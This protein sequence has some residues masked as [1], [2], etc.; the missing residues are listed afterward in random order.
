MV[1]FNPSDCP[2]LHPSLRNSYEVALSVDVVRAVGAE[3]AYVLGHIHQQTLDPAHSGVMDQAGNKWVSLSFRELSEQ[4]G[5]SVQTART[6]IKGLTD[7]GYLYVY[8]APHLRNTNCYRVNV[9]AVVRAV[10]NLPKK[11][12]QQA[13]LIP[14]VAD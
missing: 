2:P 8:S 1:D 7:G 6:A 11:T 4:L 9:A 13:F 12:A 10:G 5:L 3:A 14:V